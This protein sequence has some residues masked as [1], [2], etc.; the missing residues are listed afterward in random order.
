[1]FRLFC[2]RILGMRAWVAA[3]LEYWHWL[4]TLHLS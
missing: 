4:D 3:L 1:M 2:M